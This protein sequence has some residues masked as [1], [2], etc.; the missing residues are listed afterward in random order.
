MTT[1]TIISEIICLIIVFLI[2]LNMYEPVYYGYKDKGY[3]DKQYERIKIPLIFY[4][5]AVIVCITPILNIIGTIG[6]IVWCMCKYFDDDWI[7]KGP[8]GKIGKF[9]SK[10][11]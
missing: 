9:L 5:I 10:P 7:I 8:I 2:M 11:L 6:Y 1:F 4:I 3:K